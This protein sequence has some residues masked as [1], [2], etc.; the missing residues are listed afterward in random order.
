MVKHAAKQA[1]REAQ[2]KKDAVQFSDDRCRE[3]LVW[4]CWLG[5]RMRFNFP[6]TG[7]GNSRFGVVGLGRDG[8][9]LAVKS[10][11]KGGRTP[12]SSVL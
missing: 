4:S 6:T 2:A 3:L 12:K 7:V 10:I 1:P 8:C 9:F 11:A 5:A